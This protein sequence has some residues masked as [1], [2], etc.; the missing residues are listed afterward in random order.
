[1]FFK[2]GVNNHSS[3]SILSSIRDIREEL[4]VVKNNKLLNII[5]NDEGKE[6]LVID[7]REVAEM[8]GK[9]HKE[10]MLADVINLA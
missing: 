9:E 6:I 7:S 1:M 3:F 8:M 10:I 4:N 5:T 2:R